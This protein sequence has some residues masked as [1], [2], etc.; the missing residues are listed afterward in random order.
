MTSPMPEP[1]PVTNAVLPVRSNIVFHSISQYPKA[2]DLDLA[3][4]SV[5]QKDR[6]FSRKTHAWRRPSRDNIARFKR[7]G[8]RKVFDQLRYLKDQLIGVRILHCFAIEPELN[9]ER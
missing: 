5:L 7:D 8:T 9:A 1:A 4:I 6:R 3:N 2:I